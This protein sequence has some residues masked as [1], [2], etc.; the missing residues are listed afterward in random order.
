MVLGNKAHHEGSTHESDANQNN[1]GTG[2]DI[3]LLQGNGNFQNTM[4]WIEFDNI[5][6]CF[7]IPCSSLK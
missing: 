6:V 5:Q 7:L 1:I 2:K 3:W 4:R